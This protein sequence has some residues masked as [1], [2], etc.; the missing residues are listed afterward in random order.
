M[1]YILSSAEFSE[2]RMYR[3]HLTRKWCS[4]N[5]MAMFIG[6]NPS[7]A[8]EK[9]DD[10]TIR[11]CVGFA[12]RLHCDGMFMMNIFAFR[13]TDPKVM[14]LVVDPVGRL[15]NQWLKIKSAESAFHIACWGVHGSHMNRGEEVKALL[16]GLECFGTTKDGHPKHP[17]YLKSDTKLVSF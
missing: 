11:R 8:D 3:Y 9:E 10:P 6:L 5:R 14:K 15:N 12:Q 13:S 1:Q 17:L 4:G 2:C 16:T 7:T